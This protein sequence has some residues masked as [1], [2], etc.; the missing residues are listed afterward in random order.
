MPK[1]LTQK[2]FISKSKNVH[3]DRYDYSKTVYTK[4]ISKVI[5]TCPLHGDFEQRAFHHYKDGHGCYKCKKSHQPKDVQKFVQQVSEI[6]NNRY[7]YDL[8]EYQNA[9]NKIIIIC[10][11]HGKFMQT[12]HNHLKGNGCKKCA[13]SKGESIIAETLESRNIKYETQKTFDGCKDKYKLR[14][15]FYLPEHNIIIE[16]HGEQHYKYVERFHRSQTGY[17]AHRNRDIIKSKW[18]EENNIWL[19]TIPYNEIDILEEIIDVFI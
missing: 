19:L 11:V 7:N 9:K 13:S 3:G 16:F 4:A 5:I 8:V 15:D 12:P 10:P 2:D 14:F 6:H 18:A 17:I 1:T